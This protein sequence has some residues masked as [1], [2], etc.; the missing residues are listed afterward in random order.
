MRAMFALWL[1]RAGEL[2]SEMALARFRLTLGGDRMNGEL[3]GEDVY[4]GVLVRPGF[5]CLGGDAECGS[6]G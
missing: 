4:D 3:I 5:L 2:A 6:F 1:R